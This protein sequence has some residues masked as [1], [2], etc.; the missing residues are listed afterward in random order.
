MGFSNELVKI[1]AFLGEEDSEETDA[2]LFFTAAHS[3]A[4]VFFTSDAEGSVTFFTFEDFDAWADS[5][6]TA[7]AVVLVV[8]VSSRTYYSGA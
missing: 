8:E 6:G 7:D 1:F 3:A 5:P 4:L 2:F